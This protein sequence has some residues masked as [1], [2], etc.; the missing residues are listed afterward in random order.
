MGIRHSGQGEV[1][2]RSWAAEKT[3]LKMRGILTAVSEI[4]QRSARRW[5][6]QRKRFDPEEWQKAISARLLTKLSKMNNGRLLQ[7]VP[8]YKGDQ[9]Y[10]F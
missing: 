8:H 2:S 4:Y 10:R 7:D 6:W 1:E 9:N 3:P 5:L